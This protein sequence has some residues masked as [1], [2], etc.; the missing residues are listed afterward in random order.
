MATDPRPHTAQLP[1]GDEDRDTEE[2]FRVLFSITQG[3][4]SPRPTDLPSLLL[5]AQEMW[6]RLNARQG[7]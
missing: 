2:R 6:D 1:N 7:A 5:F 3:T 4:K